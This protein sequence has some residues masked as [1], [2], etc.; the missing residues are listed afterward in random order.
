MVICRISGLWSRPVFN[1]TS[2]HTHKKWIELNAYTMNSY[3]KFLFDT[4][5]EIENKIQ[6]NRCRCQILLP[7]RVWVCVCLCMCFHLNLLN[8]F[9]NLLILPLHI[10]TYKQT[11]TF[12]IPYGQNSCML[13]M[14]EQTA[15]KKIWDQSQNADR[16][17]SSRMAYQRNQLTKWNRKY[18][19]ELKKM[20]YSW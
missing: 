6:A 7:F 2:T 5:N 9:T 19:N 20:G 8:A 12:P 10:Q 13:P 4:R 15:H 3:Y 11:L 17:R 1:V 14:T 16:N 18:E